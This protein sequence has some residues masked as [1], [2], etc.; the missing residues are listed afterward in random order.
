[1][2]TIIAYQR[3]NSW[4]LFKKRNGWAAII[5]CNT[6]Y[7][8]WILWSRDTIVAKWTIRPKQSPSL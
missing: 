4:I 2:N 1:M 5:S 3:S 8:K 7:M 6:E